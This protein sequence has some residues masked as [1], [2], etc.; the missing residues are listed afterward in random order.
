MWLNII[1]AKLNSSEL[2]IISDEFNSGLNKEGIHQEI[3]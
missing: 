1:Q 2:L 3:E